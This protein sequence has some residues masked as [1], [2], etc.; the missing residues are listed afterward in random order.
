MGIKGN[1]PVLFADLFDAKPLRSIAAHEF[2]KASDRD[3]TRSRH[4]LQES[5]THLVVTGFPDKLPEPGNLFGG[6]G[7]VTV[8]RVSVPVLDVDLLDPAQ[9]QL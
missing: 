3:S 4:E 6:P 8:D 1:V 2:G 9:Q 5:G 7:V